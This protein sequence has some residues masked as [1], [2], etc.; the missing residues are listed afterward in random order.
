MFSIFPG[1]Q[2]QETQNQPASEV[3]TLDQAIALALENNLGLKVEKLNPQI[4]DT[5][6]VEETGRFEPLFQTNL[7]NE[8][9]D[10]PTGSRLA[11]EGTL[12][13][14]NLNY[15]LRLD[16]LLPTS[17]SYNVVFNNTRFETNQ[18]FTSF[19]PRYD[20]SLFANVRQPILRNFGREITLTPVNIAK[21]NRLASD[22]RLQTRA[23]DIEL[24]VTQAYLD[25][26]FSNAELQVFQQSLAYARDLYENNK[27]Q[28]E[29]G[30]MAPLEVVVAEAEVATREQ[31]IIA[32]ETAIENNQDRLRTLIF[33]GKVADWERTI[34]LP[35]KPPEFKDVNITEEEAIQKALSNNPDIEAL[36]MDLKSRNL[37]TK[38]ARNA[39]KP[40]LDV[41]GGFG[42]TG[43]GGPRILFNDDIFN[44][45]PIGVESGSYGDALSTMFENPTWTVGIIMELPI[46]NKQAE[47][48][49]VR[50]DI[51]ESQTKLIL[52]DTK[53]QL[54]QNVR[55]AL[56]NI[57]ASLKLIES[58]RASVVLQEKKLDAERKK[59]NVGLSTNNVVLDFQEDLARARSA[60]L[61]AIIGY[62]KNVAQLDRFMGERIKFEGVIQQ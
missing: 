19:N 48:G 60:E 51:T 61:L 46:G 22:A 14:K 41:T 23:L 24:A 31:A 50:A 45:T 7:S 28:V 11:G 3:M 4:E 20:S 58:S 39:T 55:T 6:V 10:I 35:G 13:N 36:E 21:S 18:L 49:Y 40:L 30:T 1:L 44:P 47:A 57:K 52:E 26:A 33:G 62:L 56:R 17:T 16:Q 38:L 42:W 15:N 34:L 32:G 5:F 12:R 25:Y 8:N 43:L 54:I 37:S 27:K 29:V 9:S 59:L 53:V 2:A